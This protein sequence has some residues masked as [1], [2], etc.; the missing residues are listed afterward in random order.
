M[1]GC[2][3]LCVSVQHLCAG[4]TQTSEGYIRF[5]STGVIGG[6]KFPVVGVEPGSSVRETVTLNH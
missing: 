2:L 3:G 6:C 5:H 4:H 1:C